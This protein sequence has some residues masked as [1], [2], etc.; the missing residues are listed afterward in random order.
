LDVGHNSKENKD[1]GKEITG[2]FAESIRL[3]PYQT[4]MYAVLKKE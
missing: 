3:Y 2:H 1:L 4:Y